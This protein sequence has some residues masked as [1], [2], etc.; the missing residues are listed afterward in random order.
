VIVLAAGTATAPR[1]QSTR[2]IFRPPQAPLLSART[3]STAA[4][5]AAGVRPGEPPGRRG[6]SA[7]PAAP[8]ARQRPSHLYPVVGL[9]P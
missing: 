5:T 4:S 3:A 7:S 1:S 6:R 9:T 2:P 8:A